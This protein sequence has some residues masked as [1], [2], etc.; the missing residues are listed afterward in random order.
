MTAIDGGVAASAPNAL[1]HTERYDANTDPEMLW[2]FPVA[3]GDY[4]VNFDD[5][6]SVARAPVLPRAVDRDDTSGVA[7]GVHFPGDDLVRGLHF[8]E[9]VEQTDWSAD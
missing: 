6:D 7:E 9:A 1:F 8:A 2:E 5:L 4:I 3:A